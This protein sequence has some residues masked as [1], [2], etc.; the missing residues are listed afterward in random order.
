VTIRTDLFDNSQRDGTNDEING[1]EVDANPNT[2]ANILDGTTTTDLAQSGTVDFLA[3]SSRVGL[4]SINLANAAG[5]VYPGFTIEWDPADSANLTDNSSGIGLNFKMPD[6]ADNQDIFAALN[7]MVISDATGD[8]EGEFSFNLRKDGTVTELATLAP[9]TGFTLGVND[10]GYDMKLFGAT[11]GAYCLWDES[12]DDLKLVGAAGLTVAGTSALTVTTASTITA[13]G[14]A[15][16]ASLICTAGATFGGGIG[17]TGVTISTAGVIQANGAITSDGAV[18]GATLAG[19]ISTATQNSI[20]AATALASVGA[21]NS[22]SITSGFG[23]IDTGSSTITTTG[24]IAAGSLDISGN[25]DIDGTTNLDVVDIDGAVQVDATVTV[26]VNDTGYDV[27]FFGATSGAYCLWDESADDLKLVGAAGLTVAG[28]SALTAVT[29]TTIAAAGDV[30]V[31]GTG[32]TPRLAIHADTTSS[33]VPSL[34]LMRGTDDGFGVDAYVDWRIKNDGGDLKFQTG[35]NTTTTTRFTMGSGG[36]ITVPGTITIADDQ[37]IGLGSS[38]G[39]IE[40]DDQGTDE[41][42]FLNCRVGIGTST[43]SYTLDVSKSVSADWVARVNNTN[44]T[45]GYGLLIQAGAADGTSDILNLQNAAGTAMAVF[46]GDGNVGIGTATPQYKHTGSGAY[47]ATRLAVISSLEDDGAYLGSTHANKGSYLWLGA[48]NAS[49]EQVRIGGI[50]S[51]MTTDTDGSEAGDLRF[52]V[53]PGTGTTKKMTLDKDGNLGIGT[54]PVTAHSTLSM[55][56]IG[57]NATMTAEAAVGVSKGF[58]ISQNSRYDAD[59]SYEYISTDEASMYRQL[60]GVHKFFTAASGTADTDISFGTPKMTIDNSGNVGIGIS[61]SLTAKLSVSGDIDL[62]TTGNRIDLDT[63]NDTSI[64]ASADDV[65]IIELQGNDTLSLDGSTAVKRFTMQSFVTDSEDVLIEAKKPASSSAGSNGFKWTEG[66]GNGDAGNMAYQLT[67]H[68]GLQW[69][70]M[71]SQDTDG[72]STEA[73]VWRIPDG[74][75]SIDA[76]TTWDDNVFDYVCDSCGKHRAVEFECC[77]PVAWHDDVALM[78][79][80]VQGLHQNKSVVRGLEKLGVVN[81]YGTLDTDKPELFT[82][83]QPMDWFL[84]SGM[85]Q[86]RQLIDS[87]RSEIEALRKAE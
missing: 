15:T 58:E 42:N 51:V 27:K 52:F 11:S 55:L 30:V 62:V 60:H 18:T 20:T 57:G 19:T 32:A 69:I 14:V 75:L 45:N 67:Y 71:S 35:Q 48:A 3:T 86:N 77:G 68:A 1:S 31:K 78:Q 74:Q 2:L 7:V 44:T 6:D 23:T 79:T 40:F 72:S 61:S 53:N 36:A 33:P 46:Q 49:S 39:H 25:V 80:V 4:R 70:K 17:S 63:D 29:T 76:N 13:S 64:R 24:E 41:I 56:Q 85:V 10:T 21:L 16:L 38:K 28:T 9:T 66:S 34:D 87:L 81:T 65:V 59:G 12:A 37:W 8:E 54:A 22:G 43:P 83:Q 84:M 73:D 50:G 26:G 82:C 47:N 5:S